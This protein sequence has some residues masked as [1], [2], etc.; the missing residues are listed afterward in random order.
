MKERESILGSKSIDAHACVTFY[1]FDSD[2]NFN[3]E[4]AC[5]RTAFIVQ[6]IL[7]FFVHFPLFA[8]DLLVENYMYLLHFTTIVNFSHA[9]SFFP[10]F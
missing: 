4:L 6:T 2:N 3:F 5:F 10:Y 1:S 9:S 8:S 7:A